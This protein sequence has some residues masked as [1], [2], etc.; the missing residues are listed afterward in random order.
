MEWMVSKTIVCYPTTHFSN[1][2]HIIVDARNDEIRQLYP[3]TS[4]PHRED[5]VKDGREMSPT[6][7]LVNIIAELFQIDVGSIKIG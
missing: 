6:D 7:A 1:H 2:T 4:I 3:Y 5:G